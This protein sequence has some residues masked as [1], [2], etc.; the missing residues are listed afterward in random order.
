LACWRDDGCRARVCP[1]GYLSERLLGGGEAKGIAT[2]NI[3]RADRGRR[4][5]K[6][7]KQPQG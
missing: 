1:E 5:P 7:A 4:E 6:A 2:S 3:G